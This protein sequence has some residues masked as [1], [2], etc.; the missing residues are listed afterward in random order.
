MPGCGGPA[1][2]ASP[3]GPPP[4]LA[5]RPAA[6]A[7][8]ASRM[9]RRP[10]LLCGAAALL[11]GA[12]LAA[13]KVTCSRAKD[14]TMPAK[15]PVNFF[16]STSPVIDFFLGQLDHAELVRQ[17]SEVT[18]F[19]F[20]APWC[21]QSIAA[22]EDIEKVAISL[23]DQVLFVAINCWWNQGRCRKQ[24][25]FF[26]FPVIYL[27]HRS[28]GP[29][30][31]KG[32]LNAV[33]IEKFV[34]RVMTPL[35]YISSQSSLQRFLS[36]YEPGVLGYFEFNHSPQPPG[37]LTFFT[38]A[39]HSLHKDYLGTIHFG[40]I[41]DKLI[42]KEIPLT[43][44]GSVYLHRHINTSLL[45]PHEAMN[46]TAENICRWALENQETFVRWLRPHGGK[47]LLLNNELKK[48]P[49]LFLFLPFD[50]L[51]EN[52]PLVDEISSLALAYSSCNRSGPGGPGTDHLW[53][54]GGGGE[55]SATAIPLPLAE[56]FPVSPSPCCNTVLLP[57]QLPAISRTHNVCE[58]CV[59]QSVG[60]QPSRLGSPHCSFFEIEAALDSFYL[61]ERT[62]L[63]VVSK[64]ASL[65]SN[66]LSFY[67]PFSY[68]TACCR[69][70]PRGTLGLFGSPST[71]LLPLEM[72]FSSRGKRWTEEPP[73]STPHIE[74]RDGL[75]LDGSVPRSDL[76]GLSCRTNKTL[77]L[78]LLDSNLFWMYAERL[79]APKV[80]SLKEFAVIVDLKEEAHYV[81]G[82][83]QALIRS[84][85]ETFIR[86]YS[87]VY[88]PLKRCLVGHTRPAHSGA[89]HRIREVATD[90]FQEVVLRS[91]KDVLLLYYAPWCGFCAALNHVFIQLA[92]ILPNN[93][94]VARVDVSQNDLP[95]EFMTDHLPNI[96]FFP[97][98]R[99]EQSVKFPEDF[100]VTLP[101]L[102]RFL[103]RHTSPPPPGA[104]SQPDLLQGRL[105]LLEREI[106]QLRVEAR[107]L[108]EAQALLRAQLSEARKEEQRL[109]RESQ[110]LQKQQGALQ[111]L[112]NQ[113]ARE[114]A[115]VAGKLQEL[116]QA[117]QTLLA[118]N[119]LLKVLLASV[120]RKRGA[121]LE[122]GL[123]Q[124]E[125]G[126]VVPAGEKN[127]NAPLETRIASE[128]SKENWTE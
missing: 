78:Y 59:N 33:Y 106:Q 1:G 90:T 69:T 71:P 27:Y 96:L 13:L 105:S 87:V 36:S 35:L 31:Y 84:H 55:T 81:L 43:N 12:F 98:Q 111:T 99:K 32:P 86:N 93:F 76:T 83:G 38:S 67:S 37:Y 103:L 18:L 104:G 97:L 23:A 40:V 120:E 15:L 5:R 2:L 79:G 70:V 116:A 19:F 61:K 74:V 119:T 92:R 112:Y 73:R 124:E 118:E 107:A 94:I 82:Q 113:K 49:A 101:N 68:Y 25:H 100:P 7:A 65:C 41:T 20:Y 80:A 21:G 122:S 85:L 51:A 52:Q 50:P 62:F 45:Y 125:A 48:G 3:S 121:E 44:S 89:Q 34:R 4:P 128:H 88:S 14:V 110:A 16:S 8:A 91:D 39:L 123:A 53:G 66:F 127:E 57:P 63:Q 58:L 56:P 114:L 6:A 29:I 72:A 77:N 24:K 126:L 108:R 26:Y 22:R 9:A 17:D 95:W 47:S 10:E 102:L 115:E 42:A 30:E 117:S 109:Q 46:Y 64:S 11:A 60:V 28:F 75:L 54:G